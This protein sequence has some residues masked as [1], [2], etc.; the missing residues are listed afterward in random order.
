MTVTVHSLPL[1][2]SRAYLIEAGADLILVDAG[3]PG[4]GRRILRT[5]GRLRPARLRAIFITHA[6]FDHYGSAAALRRATGA[7]VAIHALDADAMTRGETPIASA[8]GWGRIGFAAFRGT[9][10]IL[11]APATPPDITLQDGDPLPGT[12]LPACVLHTPGHT[13]GSSC[14]IVDRRLAFAGDLVSSHAGCHAQRFFAVDWA[15]IP[16]SLHRLQALEPEATYPGHGRLTLDR[17]CLLR[18][19][20]PVP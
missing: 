15:Q 19:R 9:N 10:R 17:A 4:E 12:S 18:L 5:I 6:H 16:E 14:L 11:R 7:P 2:M 13:P 1:A 3:C 20:A 8:R